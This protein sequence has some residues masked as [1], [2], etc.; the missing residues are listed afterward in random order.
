MEFTI[1]V[2]GASCVGKTSLIH[3]YVQHIFV[4]DQYEPTIED[5]YRK[6]TVV[7]GESYSLIIIDTAGS[8]QYSLMLEQHN[9]EWGWLSLCL[10]SR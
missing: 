1:V 4:Q 7:D 3:N 10:F 8:E 5:S 9:T 6:Q 2:V